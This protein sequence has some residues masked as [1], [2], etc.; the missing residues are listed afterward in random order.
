MIPYYLGFVAFVFLA[1]RT[2]NK[3]PLYLYLAAILCALAVLA[4]G[5]AGLG[6]PL[7]IFSPTW[8]HRNWRRLRRPQM[9]YGVRRRAGRLRGRRRPLAPRDAHPP[10]PAV[11]ERAVRRQ[12]LAAHGHRP[13]R[14]SRIVRVLPARAR[15]RDAALGRGGAGGARLGG[16]AP[17]GAGRRRRPRGGRRGASSRCIWLGAIWFVSSYAIVSLSMT[18]FHHYVLPAIPGL[19]IVVGCFLDDLVRRAGLAHRRGG[20]GV[21][22]P[23][24]LLITAR[25][26]SSQERRASASSGCSR[27]TTCRARTAAPGRRRSTSPRRSSSSRSSSPSGPRCSSG[28]A[29]GASASWRASR[30]GH[31]L[32]LLPARRLHARRRAVLVAEGADRHLLRAAPLA[33]RAALSPT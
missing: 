32:H 21:G 4:K 2:R 7:I 18:K 6:L 27:T 33:R 9:L 14:R 8:L 12:P 26:G 31:R 13:A 20:A 23:L 5:L 3:A 19:A 11:L 22:L 1:A 15:L 16:L 25:S 30:G 28:R 10:R 24:L 17:A 29:R